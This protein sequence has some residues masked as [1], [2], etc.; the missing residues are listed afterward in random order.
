MIEA[1]RAGNAQIAF[2]GPA[3]Y[4][5]AVLTGVEIDPLVVPRHSNGMTGYYSV[6][7]V[8]ADSPYKTIDDLAGKTSPSSTRT[9]PPA[10]T[11]RASSWTA[12]ARPSTPSSQVLLRRQP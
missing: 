7:Y 3:S 12:P 5:R 8:K 9:R 6:I 10:T 11:P 1:Q 2:Y 4:A